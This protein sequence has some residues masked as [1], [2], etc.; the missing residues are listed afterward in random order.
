[1]KIDKPN[2]LKRYEVCIRKDLHT[3]SLTAEGDNDAQ[4]LVHVCDFQSASMSGCDEY[5]YKNVHSLLPPSN[6]SKLP[7]FI[8]PG[9]NDWNDCP[10]PDT[11]WG[12]FWNY[13]GRFEEL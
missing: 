11:A 9:D 3:I 10:H 2:F 6:S 13:F 12:H 5:A 1:M 8:L 4:F 7:M